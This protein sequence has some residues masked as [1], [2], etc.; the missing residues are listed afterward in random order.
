[1][2]SKITYLIYLIQNSISFLEDEKEEIIE[3][4]LQNK[5]NLILTN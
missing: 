4:I 3:Y 2:N 5:V 1:M